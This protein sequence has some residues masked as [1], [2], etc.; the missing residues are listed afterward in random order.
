MAN[1]K[2]TVQRLADA[3]ARTGSWQKVSIEIFQEHG[4]IIPRG[5][6]CRIVKTG[7]AYLPHNRIYLAA[8]GLK[9]KP[10]PRA[11]RSL[12]DMPPA[13]LKWMFEHRKS[14]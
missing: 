13:A 2:T 10:T 4:V 8:L 11:P 1:L 12:F 14:F 7:G 3:H 6:L 5:T 9:R